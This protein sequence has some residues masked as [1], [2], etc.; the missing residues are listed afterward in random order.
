[1]EYAKDINV[2]VLNGLTLAKIEN[3]GST[4]EV[5]TQDGRH[6]RFYHDQDCCESVEVHDVKGEPSDLIGTPILS[7]VEEI[8]PSEY[9]PADVPK[10]EYSESTTWTV[11]TFTTAKGTVVMRWLGESNGYYSESVSFT[12]IKS[13]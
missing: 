3:L 7:V 6:F 11:F 8:H 4:V 13:A 5:E 2:I 10:P 9:W 12:E 1:M